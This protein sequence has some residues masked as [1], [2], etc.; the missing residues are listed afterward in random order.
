MRKLN[1][2]LTQAEITS[3]NHVVTWLMGI[4]VLVFVTFTLLQMC[5]LNVT[6]TCNYNSE[7]TDAMYRVEHAN[8]NESISLNSIR[9]KY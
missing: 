2:L 5:F 9:C 1:N 8:I 4:D 6:S 3:G 7:H